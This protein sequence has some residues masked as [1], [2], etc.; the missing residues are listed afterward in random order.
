M[1]QQTLQEKLDLLGGNI[2]PSL[3]DYLSIETLRYYM[4]QDNVYVVD[5]ES[6]IYD[7]GLTYI[8]NTYTFS[9]L[10]KIFKNNPTFNYIIYSFTP[11]PSTGDF[12][13]K[14]LTFPPNLI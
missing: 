9:D 11:N 7:D 4:N 6:F 12:I 14:G 3:K 8:M 1:T 5:S 13:I 2:D 10:I